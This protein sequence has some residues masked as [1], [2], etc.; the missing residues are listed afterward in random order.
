MENKSK[1]VDA[2]VPKHWDINGKPHRE[3]GPNGDKS[4]YLNGKLHREDG[5]AIELTSGT[6]YWYL[7]GKQLTEIEFN[8]RT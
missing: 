6:K 3:D 5:P 7:N 8:Q 4:W 2:D 1:K